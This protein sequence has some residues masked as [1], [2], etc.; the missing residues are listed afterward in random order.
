MLVAYMF[1]FLIYVAISIGIGCYREEE[2]IDERLPNRFKKEDEDE[3]N[4]MKGERKLVHIFI[5]VIFFPWPIFRLL[6]DLGELTL[7]EVKE[8]LLKDKGK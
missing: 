3:Y 6:R 7:D 1:L 2:D 8:L 4:C 5:D